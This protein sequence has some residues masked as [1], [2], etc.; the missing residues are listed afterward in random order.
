[1]AASC[2][3]WIRPA[4]TAACCRRF[5]RALPPRSRKRITLVG[6]ETDRAAIDAADA[7]LRPL[8]VKQ[9]TLVTG[10]FLEA[11]GGG[12]EL[13]GPTAVLDADSAAGFDAVIANPP[14][15]RTQVLGARRA[16]LLATRFGLTG[17]VDLYHAFARAMA[18]VIKPG[19]VLGLLASNRF[20][21]VKSGAALRA[22]LRTQFALAGHLRSRRHETF[23]GLRVAGD[24]GGHKKSSPAAQPLPL[25]SCLP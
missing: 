12:P 15:V 24:C 18:G 21:T 8:G 20:L 19:G 22:M 10:D 7:V 13:R 1:M 9:L 4:A 23:R 2:A 17:R 5:A 14:Y 6:Y 25:R 3:S 16:G 11:A